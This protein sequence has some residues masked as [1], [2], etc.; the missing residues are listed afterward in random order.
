MFPSAVDRIIRAQRTII[1]RRVS[2]TWQEK[3]SLHGR[4]QIGFM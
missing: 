2:F 4:L 3:K 1:A